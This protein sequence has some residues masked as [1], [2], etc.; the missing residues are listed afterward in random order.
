[1]DKIGSIEDKIVISDGLELSWYHYCI[2][3]PSYIND[4]ISRALERADESVK[5]AWGE[6]TLMIWLRWPGRSVWT[7]CRRQYLLARTPDFKSFTHGGQIQ[8]NF[9]PAIP[10]FDDPS[11]LRGLALLCEADAEWMAAMPNA[12]M[13]IFYLHGRKSERP[14]SESNYRHLDIT[15]IHQSIMVHRK[16]DYDKNYATLEAQVQFVADSQ[17]QRETSDQFIP[18]GRFFFA[19]DN[20]RSHLQKQHLLASTQQMHHQRPKTRL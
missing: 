7:G 19:T 6:T 1:M 5:A 4:V 14:T 17:N 10:N 18:R 12:P 15:S 11:V 9:K 8:N 3:N 13:V 2:S 20:Y 16:L